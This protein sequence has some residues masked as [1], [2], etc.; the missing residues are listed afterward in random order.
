MAEA[1]IRKLAPK[2]AVFKVFKDLSPI[3]KLCTVHGTEHRGAESGEKHLKVVAHVVL[4]SLRAHEIVITSSAG[5][6]QAFSVCWL[7]KCAV[8]TEQLWRDIGRLQGF[9]ASQGPE[10]LHKA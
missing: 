6:S 7:A 10:R 9:S 1:P 8:A 5:N 3:R 2:R 4:Q